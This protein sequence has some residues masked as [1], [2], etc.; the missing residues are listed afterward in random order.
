MTF[1]KLC[2]DVSIPVA[3]MLLGLAAS[4]CERR[5]AALATPDPGGSYQIEWVSL[6]APATLEPSEITT[7]PVTVRNAGS[8]PI[9]PVNLALSYHW[10]DAADPKRVIVWDGRRTAI[11]R[12]IGP[13]ETHTAGLRLQA[14][15]QPGE[16]VLEVDLVREG[17]AWFSKKGSPTSSH[18]VSVR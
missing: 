18:P 2:A 13:G 12:P 3:V 17:V 15:D 14:P 1:R 4:G 8:A 7:V 6:T 5:T 10:N 11:G 9:S 16:Y